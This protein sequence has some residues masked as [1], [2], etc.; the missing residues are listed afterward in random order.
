MLFRAGIG[1]IGGG[2]G[3][4]KSGIDPTDE[5]ID[6]PEDIVIGEVGDSISGGYR[7]ACANM[8]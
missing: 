8:N 4:G 5:I 6:C 7:C 1:G 3:V 2:A